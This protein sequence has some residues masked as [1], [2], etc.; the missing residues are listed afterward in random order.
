[1]RDILFKAAGVNLSEASVRKK[2]RFLYG[3]R[4][5]KFQ[6]LIHGVVL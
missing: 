6:M 3:Y 4:Y 1:M 5:I 2:F